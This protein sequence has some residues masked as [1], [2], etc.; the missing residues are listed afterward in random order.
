MEF[1]IIIAIII[2]LI[3]LLSIIY[4]INFKKIKEMANIKELDN[5]T[6]KYPNN[7]EICK[8]ILKKLENEDVIIEEDEKSDMTVYVAM[9][10]KICI[11]NLKNSYTRIQTIAHECLHSIQNR[12]ILLFNFIFSNI[13][14]LYFIIIFL[15]A[16]FGSLPYKMTFVA[17]LCIFSLVYYSTRMFLENDAMIKARYLAKEYMEEN[18]SASQD[19]INK[20]IKQYDILNDIGIKSVHYQLLVNQLVKISIICIICFII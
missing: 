9:S 16:C 1:I 20:V 12:K 18:K 4:G 10:N 13:Y 14:L 19:E 15:L 8:S 3:T 5:I 17:I 6:S 2:F 7:K 11:G